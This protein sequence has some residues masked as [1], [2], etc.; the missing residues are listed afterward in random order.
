MNFQF[1]HGYRLNYVA[2]AAL[3]TSL[4]TPPPPCIALKINNLHQFLLKF[5]D[6]ADVH[7]RLSSCLYF[8]ANVSSS[9]HGMDAGFCVSTDNPPKNF[10]TFKYLNV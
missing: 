4:R 7:R 3:L 9:D 10:L 6:D 1:G 2:S 8:N 5:N